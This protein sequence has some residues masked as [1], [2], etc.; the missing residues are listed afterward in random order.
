MAAHP[1][2]AFHRLVLAAQLRLQQAEPRGEHSGRRIQGSAGAR[3]R[4]EPGTHL[5]HQWLRDC[6][7]DRSRE[8]QPHRRCRSPPR[9][10]RDGVLDTGTPGR[11]ASVQTPTHCKEKEIVIQNAGARHWVLLARLLPRRARSVAH[12][13]LNATI[14][15]PHP[16]A[17]KRTNIQLGMTSIAPSRKQCHPQ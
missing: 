17:D 16:R 8:R 5:R 11:S 1:D 2:A 6:G 9:L 15:I 12:I 13:R 14:A 3:A 7:S 10:L 4:R